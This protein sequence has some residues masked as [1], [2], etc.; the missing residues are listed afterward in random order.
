MRILFLLLIL[1]GI[2]CPSSAGFHAN[3]QRWST[4]KQLQ[5]GA[6]EENLEVYRVPVADK[7]KQTQQVDRM[8]SRIALD[9]SELLA[10]LLS[11]RKA[12]YERLGVLKGYTLQVY[13]G[14]SR[15]AA[16][17]A[18]EKALLVQTRYVPKL[19]YR[20]PNYTVHLGFFTDK[21]EA[22]T[23]YLA[24]IRKMPHAMVRPYAISR[25]TYLKEMREAEKP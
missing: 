8:P 3:R 19:R 23:T 2:G 20:Q 14:N 21:L 7:P 4:W 6:Y 5:K 10:L 11:K 25:E 15:K 24:L 16:L 13:M 12:A 18:Q 1:I 9:Q 22:Y 17:R